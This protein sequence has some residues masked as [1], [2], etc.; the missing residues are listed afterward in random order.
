ME[1]AL[2][3]LSS[4]HSVVGRGLT[5]G[6]LEYR[7]AP[8]LSRAQQHRC[9]E[10]TSTWETPSHSK[11]ILG[12]FRGTNPL[13]FGCAHFSTHSVDPRDQYG[14]GGAPACEE[15]KTGSRKGKAGCFSFPP[16][17]QWAFSPSSLRS[18]T[19]PGWGLVLP[20]PVL[21]DRPRALALPALGL[22]RS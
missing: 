16:L 15:N 9:C 11:V 4:T 5:T 18:R 6:I 14:W 21:R 13:C 17:A 7:E 8:G 10:G 12:T 1:Q 22:S 3:Q 2:S 19:V 20:G